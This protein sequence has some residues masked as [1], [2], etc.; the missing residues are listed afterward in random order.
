MSKI[1]GNVVGTPMKRPDFNQTDPKKSDYIL[2]NPLPIITE[3]DEG[4][5]L[6]VKD[7]KLVAIRNSFVEGEGLSIKTVNGGKLKFFVGTEEEY[8]ALPDEEKENLFALFTDDTSQAEFDTL[9]DSAMTLYGGTFIPSGSDLND[10]ITEGNYY[11]PDNNT[12]RGISNVP[13]GEG[14][15]L[16]VLS[17][18]GHRQVENAEYYYIIQMYVAINARMYIRHFVRASTNS[19]WTNWEQF[20]GHG[21]HAT[22]ADFA[23]RLELVNENFQRTGAYVGVQSNRNGDGKHRIIR[24]NT[25]GTSADDMH[26][27]YADSATRLEQTPIYEGYISLGGAYID[28]QSGSL[29]AI[30][31]TITGQTYMMYVVTA[32]I[33]KSSVSGNQAELYYFTYD[34][35]SKMLSYLAKIGDS[36]VCTSNNIKIYE[37]FKG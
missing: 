18:V 34:P 4:K 37:I 13:I 10:Y 29:Y 15:Q 20:A 1:R 32:T 7:G 16:K 36:V 25:D 31:D 2:N 8:K 33:S 22:T 19:W 5:I 6:L 28:L 23:T 26:I 14:G 35:N 12:A 11:I 24:W 3:E 30:A 21:S 17:G 9:K 27:K